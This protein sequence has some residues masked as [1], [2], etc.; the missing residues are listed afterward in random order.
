MVDVNP[1][2]TL[3]GAAV[4]GGIFL[5]AMA[6]RGLPVRPDAAGRAA[7]RRAL[8]RALTTR[9]ALA[10]IIGSAVLVVTRWPVAAGGAVL[11]VVAW[12]GLV[13]GAASERV[14]M[15]RL[16]GLA[17]WT[18]SLR[19]TIAGAAGLEQAIPASIRAAAPSL[20]PHL[21]V[22]VDRLHTRMPMPDALRR[23]ADDLDDPSADLVVAALVLNSRLRGPGL[24][25]VLSALAVSAREELD[26]RRRVEAERRSTRRS[27]QIVVG[28]AL[29]FAAL[30]VLFNRDYVEV[31]DSPLGQAVLV[32]VAALF[33]AGFAWMRRL[34][35][36]DKPARLL[37]G[38]PEGADQPASAAPGEGRRL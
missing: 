29:A 37:G 2:A 28:T 10:A 33:G 21:R 24:R 31:Y 13:G 4:G 1:L 11:L 34:A 15:R 6:I 17:A 30:L 27:V 18:E 35:R 7:R 12:H 26:M 16:E 22:L 38:A 32:V 3:A 23:F 9:S 25:D 14:A 8:L 5:L 20:Q 19:D 36:F